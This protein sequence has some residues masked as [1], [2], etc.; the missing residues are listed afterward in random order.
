MLAMWNTVSQQ[1]TFCPFSPFKPAVGLCADGAKPF[2]SGNIFDSSSPDPS[3][4]PPEPS[5]S[6]SCSQNPGGPGGPLGPTGPCIP[7]SPGGPWI[8]AS[9]WLPGDPY[10]NRTHWTTRPAFLHQPMFPFSTTSLKQSYCLHNS[11]RMHVVCLSR[12][13]LYSHA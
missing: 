8:P 1:Q 4:E 2:Q 9:P 5:T 3:P 10:K 13:V 11:N 7:G 6:T 12:Y